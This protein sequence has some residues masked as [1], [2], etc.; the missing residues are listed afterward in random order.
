MTLAPLLN[1][2]L[3]I[4]IHAIAALSLVPLTVIQFWRR[5]GG[6]NHRVL[7]WTWVGVMVVTALS[8]FWIHSIRLIGPFSPIHVLSVVTLFGLFG[9]VRA[10]RAGD[11]ARHRWIMMQITAGWFIAGAFAFLP[12]RVIFRMVI[13]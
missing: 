11:I 13:G 10:R 7:G 4:Q 8:S 2:S 9:A 3:A 1:A 6:I 5:K 12:G